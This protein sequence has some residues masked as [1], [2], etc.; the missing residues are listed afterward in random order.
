MEQEVC[1]RAKGV[2]RRVIRNHLTFAEHKRCLFADVD[3]DADSDECDDE[4]DADMGKMVAAGCARKGVAHIHRNAGTPPTHS[5][6]SSIHRRTVTA[7]CLSLHIGKMSLY[8]C[9]ST[10]FVR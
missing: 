8:G 10:N 6:P 5:S 7:I 1:I 4:F 3:D 9:S 2:M